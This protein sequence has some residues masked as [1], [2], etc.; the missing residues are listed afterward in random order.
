MLL[1]KVVGGQQG[2]LKDYATPKQK[3]E[4]IMKSVNCTVSLPPPLY[5][6]AKQ[7]ER[8]GP[9]S[10]QEAVIPFVEDRV[11]LR[12]ADAFNGR[13]ITPEAKALKEATSNIIMLGTSASGKTRTI[14]DVARKDFMIYVAC[15]VKS[16]PL[17]KTPSDV[18]TTGD[19]YSH[20]CATPFTPKFTVCGLTTPLAPELRLTDS[21]SRI[22]AL[23]C[24]LQHKFSKN[25]Q[26][27]C[28]RSSYCCN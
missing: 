3:Y 10:F 6:Q 21:F 25:I 9:F 17:D 1:C 8:F 28:L 15:L 13:E 11:D 23:G 26:K 14:F 16:E 2:I 24:C 7:N 27:L 12:F 20:N 19:K 22:S 4:A 5:N 18:Q